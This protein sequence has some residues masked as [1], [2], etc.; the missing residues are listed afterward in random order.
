MLKMKPPSIS[1]ND[2]PAF[3]I[4]IDTEGDNSWARSHS[5][6][7]RNSQFLPRFQSLCERYGLKP[8]YLTN[9]E[10]A[11]CPVFQEFARD[12]LKRNT[13]EIGMHLHSWNSPPIVPLTDD[14]WVNHPYLIE[15][16][17]PVIGEKIKVM[18]ETLQEVFEIDVVSHRAGRWSFNEVYARELIDLGYVVDCSV[19]PHLS[20]KQYKGDPN[21][22]GGTDYSAFPEE[23]YFLD[24]TDISQPGDSPLL[25]V[26][27]TVS[28]P[29]F[30]SLGRLAAGVLRREPRIG[31]RAA[32]R[33]FPR[34]ARF[35]PDGKNRRLLL[36]LLAQSEHDQRDHVEFMLHSSELMPGGSPNFP[37]HSSIEKLYDDMEVVF[38]KAAKHFVGMTLKEYHDRFCLQQGSRDTDDRIDSQNRTSKVTA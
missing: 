27:V 21:G 23:P 30:S 11:N 35:I 26:P 8:C 22:A 7:T 37:S 2:L 32:N 17:M 33:F 16:A 24:A 20:W 9:W 15:F 4:T 10:M 31:S 34:C 14:D 5:V 1:D 25:E 13:G 3:L 6:E 38:A 29:L 12:V 18:T 19:T 36:A 28:Q